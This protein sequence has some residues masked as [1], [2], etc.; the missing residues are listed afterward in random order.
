MKHLLKLRKS[1]LKLMAPAKQMYQH[2]AC[3]KIWLK[4]TISHL[5][6]NF[7]R[8]FKPVRL[9]QHLDQEVVSEAVRCI[10]TADHLHVEIHPRLNATIP[11]K[12]HEEIV[13]CPCGWRNA[14]P[15]H[16]LEYLTSP[17]KVPVLAVAQDE[18]VECGDIGRHAVEGK[19]LEHLVRVP[20][21][22]RLRERVHNGV[23]GE[24]VG[25]D[26]FLPH[27]VKQRHRLV[28]PAHDAVRVDEGPVGDH[29]RAHARV[30]HR[31]PELLHLVE[32]ARAGPP[33]EQDV[34]GPH[35]G[36]PRGFLA[37]ELLDEPRGG[38]GVALLAE[39]VDGQDQRGDAVVS[40][41]VAVRVAVEEAERAGRGV[42]AAE[43]RVAAEERGERGE[44]GR[45]RDGAGGSARRRRKGRERRGG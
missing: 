30:A 28:R 2:G 21:T 41:G 8:Q 5:P 32:P 20:E 6:K 31:R 34:V 13:V 17:S 14:P 7:Q 36:H 1:L 19:F 4:T 29:R 12:E 33:V 22:A 44:R 18:G 11:G 23:A 37:P 39:R 27:L 15:Q 16:G 10:A 25:V 45:R 9:A 3:R 24:Q 43:A 35:V 42:G 26:P 38:A 40:G